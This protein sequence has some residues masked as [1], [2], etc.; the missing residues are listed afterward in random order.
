[1]I[2][3]CLRADQQIGISWPCAGVRQHQFAGGLSYQE[4]EWLAS[5]INRAIEDVAANGDDG[6][7]IPDDDDYQDEYVN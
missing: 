6:R 2:W 1:M 5:E 7:S 3:L 4:Q